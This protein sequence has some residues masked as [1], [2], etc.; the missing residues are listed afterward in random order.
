MKHSNEW[1]GHSQQRLQFPRNKVASNDFC[2]RILAARREDETL[3][4]T[5][6]RNALRYAHHSV[7]LLD[8]RKVGLFPDADK[9]VIASGCDHTLIAAAFEHVH[10]VGERR[11]LIYDFTSLRFETALREGR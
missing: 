6:E 3:S 4:V 5:H 7:K 10:R 1:V 8:Q 9:S 2:W 11:D